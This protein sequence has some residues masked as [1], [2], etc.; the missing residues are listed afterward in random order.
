MRLELSGPTDE[1]SPAP[2]VVDRETLC[3]TPI[4]PSDELEDEA[5]YGGVRLL[6]RQGRDLDQRVGRGIQAGEL[7]E[8]HERPERAL[9]DAPGALERGPADAWLAEVDDEVDLSV[10]EYQVTS[11]IGRRG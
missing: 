8:R 9:A 11:R 4:V 5:M 7:D 2:A 6:L 1:T 10:D 3:D